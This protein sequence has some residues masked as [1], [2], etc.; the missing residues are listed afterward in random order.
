MI[1]DMH[2]A[3]IDKAEIVK[4]F[5][6]YPKDSYDYNYIFNDCIPYYDKNNFWV[7]SPAV[8]FD[9]EAKVGSICFYVYD[10]YKDLTYLDIK[11]IMTTT[12]NR[13]KGYGTTLLD[14]IINHSL[15]NDV[16]YIRMF[17]NP[18]SVDFY[19]KNGYHFHGETK[20]GYTFVFQPIAEFERDVERGYLEQEFI[21]HQIK[22]YNGFI[23]S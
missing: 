18:D 9:N 10:M 5:S 23:Y 6:N 22:K 4:L 13:G 8:L 14:T 16:K 19:R 7:T 11:R 1:F 12:E 21:H 3:K 17:C 15:Q 2:I 20:T